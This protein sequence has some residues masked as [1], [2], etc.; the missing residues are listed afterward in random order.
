[1]LAPSS[2][3]LTALLCASC[4]AQSNTDQHKRKISIGERSN[5][6]HPA[7]DFAIQ[8]FNGI[9]RADLR[10]IFRRK[11]PICQRFLCAPLHKFFQ[12]YNILRHSL[13]SFQNGCSQ[14]LLYQG[15][16]TMPFHFAQF[17]VPYR[18]PFYLTLCI[19]MSEKLA[20]D[21]I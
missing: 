6:A 13:L 17:I 19:K 5:G 8:I 9:I 10:P 11:P 18:L 7:P 14:L 1:M 3:I 21:A 15:L 16:Q 4:I 2:C 20:Y 12:L